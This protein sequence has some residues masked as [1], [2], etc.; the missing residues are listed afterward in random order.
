MTYPTMALEVYDYVQARWI[1]T[2]FEAS[3]RPHHYDYLRPIFER[4]V[5]GAKD[6]SPNQ[7]PIGYRITSNGRKVDQWD[8]GKV[9]A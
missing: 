6:G 3:N 8:N 2:P 4:L 7:K 5:A 1:K 9:P